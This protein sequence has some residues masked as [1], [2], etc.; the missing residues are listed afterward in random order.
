MAVPDSLPIVPRIAA[1]LI[2][3]APLET[4]LIFTVLALLMEI[5]ESRS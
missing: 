5:E 1:V 2:A 3:D 4:A